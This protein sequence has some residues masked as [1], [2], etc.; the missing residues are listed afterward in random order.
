MAERETQKLERKDF[1]HRKDFFAS[2]KANPTEGNLTSFHKARNKCASTLSRAR[3]Q[4]LSNF[5]SELSNLSPSSKSWWHLIKSLSGVCSPSIPSH[6]SNGC[7]ADTTREKT[8]SLNSVF[9]AK[10][11]VQNRLLSLPTLPSR[12][13]LSLDSVSFSSDKVETCCQTLTQILQPVQT[14]SAHVS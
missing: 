11:C 1:F 2:W 3:K 7:T 10:S 12:T 4:H 5:K 8:E 9:A 6:S 14:A 13:Q